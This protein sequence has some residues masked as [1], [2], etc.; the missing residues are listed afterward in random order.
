MTKRTIMRTSNYLWAALAT[1]ALSLAA[2][3]G[4]E[5]ENELQPKEKTAKVELFLTGTPAETKATGTLPTSEVKINRVAVGIFDHSTG[6]TNTIAE[7]TLDK[8]KKYTFN[9]MPGT[10]DIIVV[11][12]APTGTFKGLTTKKAFIEK[13]VALSQTATSDVQDANNLPMSGKAESV[14]LTAG[15]EKAQTISLSR[16]VARVCINSVKTAFDAKGQY[17]NATFTLKKVFLHNAM[18]TSQVTPEAAPTTSSP[19][20]GKA[21]ASNKYLQTALATPAA[22]TTAAHTTNYWFYTFANTNAA[23]TKL[24]LFGAFDPDGAG[25]T[26][27]TDVYYPVVINKKQ[28]GTTITGGTDAQKGT[29]TVLRNTLYNITATIKGKG[30]DDPDKDIEPATLVLTVN[31]ADW[32]LTITQDVTFE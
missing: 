17:A 15:Q 24:V 19:Q 31:V 26:A 14:V 10:C 22:I 27:A 4:D 28:P 3:G 21:D 25:G 8:D 2:C 9:C 12:N 11:A 5:N 23:K 1:A 16:L 13:T 32:A 29:S 20:T 18:A 7:P 30:V 6:A